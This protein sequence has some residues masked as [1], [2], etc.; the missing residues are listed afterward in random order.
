MTAL[1][2][3]GGISSVILFL[4]NFATDGVI[5]DDEIGACSIVFAIGVIVSSLIGWPATALIEWKLPKYRLRYVVAGVACA[6]IGWLLLGGAFGENA[7]EEIWMNSHFWLRAPR[8]ALFFG[9]IGLLTGTI[10]TAL[11]LLID[12]FI[13]QRRLLGKQRDVMR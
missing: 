7:W 4:M 13:P 2:L 8:S 12:K 1:S 10:Y 9:L 3:C 6:L 5:S 11:F